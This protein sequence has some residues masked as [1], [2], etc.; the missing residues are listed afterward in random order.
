MLVLDDS[1]YRDTPKTFVI[2]IIT[3]N[4]YTSVKFLP[5]EIHQAVQLK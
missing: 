3:F 1:Y 5:E 2:K 4:S